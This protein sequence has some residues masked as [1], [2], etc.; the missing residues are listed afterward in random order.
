M[1][2][3]VLFSE[4]HTWQHRAHCSG[5]S[6]RRRERISIAW[7]HAVAAPNLP[8]P[9]FDAALT[10]KKWGAHRIGDANE[11]E[12]EKTRPCNIIC[13]SHCP[14][15]HALNFMHA[16]SAVCVCERR[17]QCRGGVSARR[18]CWA[19]EWKCRWMGFLCLFQRCMARFRVKWIIVLRVCLFSKVIPY[20]HVAAFMSGHSPAR[21]LF[22]LRIRPAIKTWLPTRDAHTL[23]AWWPLGDEISACSVGGSRILQIVATFFARQFLIY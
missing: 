6:P 13:N 1:H 20:H 11:R 8:L 16:P 17:R 7:K 19:D 18:Y 5:T 4:L 10:H 22:A 12:V 14:R 23:I 3:Y 21:R 2:V 15:L 9:V